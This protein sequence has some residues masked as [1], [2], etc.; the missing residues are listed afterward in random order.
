MLRDWRGIG[1]ACLTPQVPERPDSQC[2]A[3]AGSLP[4]QGTKYN[5]IAFPPVSPGKRTWGGRPWRVI[6]FLMSLEDLCM[7]IWNRGMD[8]LKGAFWCA[9]TR[10]RASS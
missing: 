3:E 4:L 2:C 1:A 9:K 7:R 5:L 10:L 8:E 6:I